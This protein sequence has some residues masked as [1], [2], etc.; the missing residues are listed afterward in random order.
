[1]RISRRGNYVLD[2]DPE[3]GDENRLLDAEAEWASQWEPTMNRLH[4]AVQDTEATT[5]PRTEMEVVISLRPQQ[6]LRIK[7]VA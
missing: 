7:I 6:A 1:M 4:A 3:P 2:L 5:G